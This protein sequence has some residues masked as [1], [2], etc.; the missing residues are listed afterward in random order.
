M[1]G[2]R[3]PCDTLP[4]DDACGVALAPISDVPLGNATF[5]VDGGYG[6]YFL[7]TNKIWGHTPSFEHG[8]VNAANVYP[9][10]PS[11]EIGTQSKPS[12]ILPGDPMYNVSV[13]RHRLTGDYAP[14]LG[15]ERD[16]DG[17]PAPAVPNALNWYAAWTRPRGYESEDTPEY[18]KQ[19]PRA[20][21]ALPRG[22]AATM[23]F[24]ASTFRPLLPPTC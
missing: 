12:T 21:S 2:C 20:A 1:C 17:A 22:R 7:A 10:K 4:C 14:T 23:R 11:N 9:W 18:L 24:S 15:S 3:P 5:A 6:D 19:R 8:G 13:L 16:R